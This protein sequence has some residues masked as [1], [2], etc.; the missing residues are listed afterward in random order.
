M[1]QDTLL[2]TEH[3]YGFKGLVWLYLYHKLAAEVVCQVGGVGTEA[4][5]NHK[6]GVIYKSSGNGG[7]SRVERGTFDLRSLVMAHFCRY[8]SAG[9]IADIPVMLMKQSERRCRTYKRNKI[10]APTTLRKG[11]HTIL[12]RTALCPK[13]LAECTWLTGKGCLH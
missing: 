6:R 5:T 3:T 2:C 11:K 10:V 12:N 8:D 1:D 4:D 7:Q 9:W 13:N